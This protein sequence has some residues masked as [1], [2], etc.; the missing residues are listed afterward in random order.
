MSRS[1]L[2][3]DFAHSA[4]SLGQACV[5]QPSSDA[6]RRGSRCRQR[7]NDAGRFPGRRRK[8][9]ERP[10]IAPFQARQ[11]PVPDEVAVEAQIGIGR[12]VF[13]LKTIAMRVGNDLPPPQTQHR[14][15]EKPTPKPAL[16]RH[17]AWRPPGEHLPKPRLG[18][19]VRVV[20]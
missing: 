20:G 14:P 2:T 8:P 3:V 6:F 1:V 4:V 13:P 11:Q 5:G 17:S 18:L 16:G 19:V 12:I 15:H 9:R 10:W 7:I